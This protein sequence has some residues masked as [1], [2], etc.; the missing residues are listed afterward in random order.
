MTGTMSASQPTGPRVT[1]PSDPPQA[2]AMPRPKKNPPPAAPQS[3]SG[4]GG[5]GTSKG[6]D[7]ATYSVV[8]RG[9]Q[10]RRAE[11]VMEKTGKGFSAIVRTLVDQYVERLTEEDDGSSYEVVFDK[12]FEAILREV[13]EMLS[14]DR[15][16]LLKTI[17]RENIQTYLQKA[18][19]LVKR[20]EEIKSRISHE[21]R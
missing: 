19:E 21:D 20:I 9:Q 13:A 6:K 8:L 15:T 3:A 10:R 2:T 11:A 5:G 4:S 7:Y 12:D 14:M 1:C 18:Q 17:V 16:T